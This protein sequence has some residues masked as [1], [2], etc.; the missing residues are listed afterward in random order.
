MD[1]PLVVY[2]QFKSVNLRKKYCKQK[3]NFGGA[4]LVG[5]RT[6]APGLLKY[7]EHVGDTGQSVS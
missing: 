3:Y 7:V 6:M 2:A 4:L 5:A 1:P